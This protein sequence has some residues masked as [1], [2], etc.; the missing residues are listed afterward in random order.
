MNQAQ[1]LS[2]I[3][4]AGNMPPGLSLLVA[5]GASLALLALVVVTLNLYRDSRRRA[6]HAMNACDPGAK[7]VAGLV[8]R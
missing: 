4:P 6:R 8:A 7:P 2:T 5:V 1:D 3:Y